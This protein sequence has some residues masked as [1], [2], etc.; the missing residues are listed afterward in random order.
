[1]AI[2]APTPVYSKDILFEM[3]LALALGALI[4]LERERRA[5]GIVFAGI[6]SF[7]LVTFLGYFTTFISFLV[8][9]NL[10][11]ILTFIGI[12]GIAMANHYVYLQKKQRKGITTE[13]AFII[14]FLIGSLIFYETNTYVVS[15]FSAAAL[16]FILFLREESHRFAKRIKPIELF[17]ALVF[18]LLAFVILPLLPNYY[19]DP[20][21]SLNPRRI[22]FAF[23]LIIGISWLAYILFKIQ[24]KRG[25]HL[26]GLIG[27][28][29][30]STA[31]TVDAVTNFKRNPKLAVLISASASSVMFFR[32]F[33]IIGLI[34]P[35]IV[36]YFWPLILI[37]IAGTTFSHVLIKIKK[38]TKIELKSPI[39]FKPAFYFLIMLTVVF[40]LSKFLLTILGSVSANLIA[41]FIGIPEVDAPTIAFLD[42]GLSTEILISSVLTI[43]LANTLF[44]LSLCYIM[45]SREIFREAIKPFLILIVLCVIFIVN[46][47]TARIF[48]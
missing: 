22:F 47:Q 25:A 1:M 7:T 32:Q 45:G 9:S 36:V 4:G 8:Q 33:L 18:A 2:V 28:L 38:E 6:R 44:K 30:S 21:N 40:F 31:T 5:K 23:T 48:I 14:S 27:G 26:S 37:G 13:L 15:I 20:W 24:P 10:F 35:D 39:K 12:V 41:F 42:A 19:I 43:S 46:P 34:R 11:L 17:D 29:I 3:L 16:T